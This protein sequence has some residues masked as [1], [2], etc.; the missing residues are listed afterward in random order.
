MNKVKP[1]QRSPKAEHQT[2][3]E[4]NIKETLKRENSEEEKVHA[5]IKR[6]H[7]HGLQKTDQ[8]AEK[9]VHRSTNAFFRF[10]T[11]LGTFF[12]EK[13]NILRNYPIRLPLVKYLDSFY[14]IV[15]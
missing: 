1:R 7:A 9:T 6:S 12:F 4:R 11:Y 3:R 2:V 5:N 14:N 8:E 15:R 10:R 13:L